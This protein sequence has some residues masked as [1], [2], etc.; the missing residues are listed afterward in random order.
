LKIFSHLIF[1]EAE[2]I[3][4]VFQ[5]SKKNSQHQGFSRTSD[6]ARYPFKESGIPLKKTH[7][8]DERIEE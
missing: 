2:K 7:T 3:S 1:A 8:A 5:L 6:I 4:W